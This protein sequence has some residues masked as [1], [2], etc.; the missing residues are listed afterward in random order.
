MHRDFKKHIAVRMHKYTCIFL[1]LYAFGAC[2]N[3][4]NEVAKM[5]DL[6]PTTHHENTLKIASKGINPLDTLNNPLKILFKDMFAGKRADLVTKKGYLDRFGPKKSL[7]LSFSTDSTSELLSCWTFSDTLKTQNALYNWFDCFGANCT[8]LKVGQRAIIRE[9]SGEIWVGDTLLVY[10]QS[11]N[12]MLRAVDQQLINQLFPDTL[13]FH[14]SWKKMHAI[15]W[16]GRS[17]KK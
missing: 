5:E 1:L 15:Q 2:T 16:T 8:A 3:E 13:R 11:E 6:V 9:N 10:W 12:A 7:S 17:S 4:K 14:L